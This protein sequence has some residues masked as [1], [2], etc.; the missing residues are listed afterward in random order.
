MT[1]MEAAATPEWMALLAHRVVQLDGIKARVADELGVSRTAISLALAGRYPG[2][3]GRIAAKVLARYRI[4]DCP[5]LKTDI[6]ADECR[7]YRT[8]P[9]PQSNPGELRF[10]SACQ[11]CPVGAVMARSEAIASGE[12]P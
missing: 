8:R 5:W 2:G 9:M 7:Q 10:W 6:V 1:T 11:D 3:T 12:R 4:C